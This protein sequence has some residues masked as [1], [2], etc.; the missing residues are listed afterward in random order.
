MDPTENTNSK[1]KS[2]QLIPLVEGPAFGPGPKAKLSR[3]QEPHLD[4][5]PSRVRQR[6]YARG[7]IRS[8]MEMAKFEADQCRDAL[9]DKIRSDTAIK[10]QESREKTWFDLAATAGI[11]QPFCL[12]P[13]AI[14]TVM[15]ILDRANYRSAELYLDA[16]KQKHVEQGFAWTQQLAQ[17]AR[18]A[19]RACRR[20][21]GPA[22]QAQPLPFKALAQLQD[23]QNP[24]TAN[25]PCLPVRS[26]LLAS[27]WLLRE[28]EA[29]NARTSHIKLDQAQK[30]VHWSLP[31]SKTDTEALGATRTHACCCPPLKE[32]PMCPYHLMCQQLQFA[33]QLSDGPLFP[34]V[35]GQRPDKMGWATTFEWLAQRLK[36]PLTTPSGVKRFTGQSA[37]ATGAVHLAM[38]QVELWRIQLFGRCF[39]LYIRAA[40]LSQLTHLSQET[41]VSASLAAAR[42]ELSAVL[43]KVKTLQHDVAQV[44]LAHQQVSDLADCEAAEPL[45]SHQVPASNHTSY[46][47][48]LNCSSSGKL[49][50]VVPYSPGTPHHLWHTR[51]SWYFARHAG[52]YS[53]EAAVPENTITCRKCFRNS[54]PSAHQGSDTSSST[55]SSSES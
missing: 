30:L 37:R 24:A 43:D 49:H 34:S 36:E 10:P 40:P 45:V 33:K 7:S 5:T 21:R 15:G 2:G 14:F 1:P 19:R 8:A 52:D 38:T 44:P 12:D 41:A 3:P 50:R 42:A 39:K 16:A 29:S 51:C 11:S 6:P 9:R 32:D 26:T 4:R 47:Y 53:L 35:D 27:W 18:Q 17:A 20:G 46:P 31:S 54:S 28:I 48:V 13:N 22:K 55:S 23:Q 25:G